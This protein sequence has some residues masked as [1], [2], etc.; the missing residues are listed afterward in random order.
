[1]IEVVDLVKHYRSSAGGI[2]KAVDGV[3]FAVSPGEMVGRDVADAVARGLD[4]VHLDFGEFGQ[5][6][7]GEHCQNR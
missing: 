1:M 3:S 5:R 6:T 4:R 2:V 7:A